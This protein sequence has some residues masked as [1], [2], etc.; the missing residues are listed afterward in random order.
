MKFA[1]YYEAALY[2]VLIANC[3]DISWDTSL[4]S[5]VI[6]KEVLVH[7]CDE[8]RKETKCVKCVVYFDHGLLWRI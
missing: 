8:K 7:N 4:I 6:R 3:E 2:Y 1:L 5:I